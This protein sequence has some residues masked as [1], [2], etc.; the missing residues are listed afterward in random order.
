MAMTMNLWLPQ[1]NNSK[2]L[3][4]IISLAGIKPIRASKIGRA[5]RPTVTAPQYRIYLPTGTRG[6]RAHVSP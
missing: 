2:M 1:M 5:S 6:I 3:I 4:V